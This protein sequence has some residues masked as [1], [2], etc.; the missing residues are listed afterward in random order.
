[1]RNRLRRLYRE[2]FRLTRPELPAGIDLVLL[3]R[4][5]EEPT[6]DALKTALLQLVPMLAGKL[7][8]T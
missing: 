3:P 6:L 2:A 1:A 5:S 4:T 8:R 7:Q